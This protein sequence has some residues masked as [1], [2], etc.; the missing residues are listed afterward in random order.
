MKKQVKWIKTVTRP[1]SPLKFPMITALA[2][3]FQEVL[4]TGFEHQI[5]FPMAGQHAFYFDE[6]EFN[7]FRESVMGKVGT[8]EG[9]VKEQAR[10]CYEI[11][12]RFVQ[13]GQKIRSMDLGSKSDSELLQ[14]YSGF[15]EGMREYT[16][17][18]WI[19][20]VIE[21]YLPMA[22]EKS[23]KLTKDDI[24]TIS[25]K[26]RLTPS[27][28]EAVELL[29]IAAEIERNKG[30]VEERLEQRIEKHAQT[31]GWLPTHDFH[32]DV[33]GKEQFVARL[34]QISDASEKLRSREQAI[35]EQEEKLRQI[36][37][38]LGSEKVLLSLIDDLQEYLFLRTYRTDA[39]YQAIYY[40]LPLIWE[41]G[42]RAKLS[43]DEIVL[44]TPWEVVNFL[45]NHQLPDTEEIERR[46][47]RY[48]LV[49]IE[50]EERIVSDPDEIEEIGKT[51]FVEE[52]KGEMVLRGQGVYPGYA[53]GAAKIVLNVREGQKIERG[54][55]LV[56]TM[57]TPEM[58][59]SIEKV[60]GIVTDEG[61]VTSHAALVSRELGIP[62]VI[63]TER[64]TQILRDGDIVEIDSKEG[65]VR[66][67]ES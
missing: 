24:N 62:S 11:C 27:D 56:S 3:D 49:R 65:V 34:N 29:K 64:A 60:S 42:R 44:F 63:G 36:R 8:K 31:F 59:S 25:T 5:Y 53:K 50:K 18:L 16:I 38:R 40:T 2:E 7:A 13:A 22:L 51:I 10:N 20:L 17:Y 4:G 57:T 21:R 6:S 23:G 32:L 19:P 12:E 47:N 66:R 35:Q 52:A 39:L 37:H 41:I 15:S 33:W 28:Q 46:K 14:L 55:I 54:D 45:K 67:V 1:M 61:G 58:H 26:T 30:V 43:S 48:V 9:Y